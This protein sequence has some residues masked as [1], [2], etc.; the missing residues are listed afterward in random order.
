MTWNLEQRQHLKFER[1]PLAAVIVQLRFH[2]ILKVADKISDFQDT[3]RTIFPEFTVG[4]TQEASLQLPMPVP[5]EIRTSKQFQFG[6][7]DKTS[8]LTLGQTSLALECRQ[9][10]GHEELLKD[11]GHAVDALGRVYRPIATTRLGMRYIN[12]IDRESIG[13]QLGEE[14]GW[15]DLVHDDYLHLPGGLCDLEQTRYGMEISS[16][17]ADGSL[18]LRYG[19]LPDEE[20]ASLRFRIDIDRYQECGFEISDTV[21][22]LRRFSSDAYNIFDHAV[23]DKLV[24]W[25][26]PTGGA[27]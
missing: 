27:S 21:E 13:A 2:P 3:V 9:H 24:A 5:V 23:G 10:R 15:S 4:V 18:T 14:V 11:F 8:V 17:I 12:I 19:V 20:Q 6:K 26:K 16:S 7:V 1:N 25:M 22:L